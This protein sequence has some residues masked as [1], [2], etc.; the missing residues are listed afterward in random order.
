MSLTGKWMELEIILSK[1]S[2]T[3]TDDSAY[4]SHMQKLVLKK[5]VNM[6]ING[7]LIGRIHGRWER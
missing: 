2:Q 7:G 5:R 3:Q 1:I 4:F 6:N